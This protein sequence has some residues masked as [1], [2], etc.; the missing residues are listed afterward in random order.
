MR[1]RGRICAAWA[2]AA[3]TIVGCAYT[4]RSSLDPKYRT[5]AVPA[6]R[7]ESS[8]YDL[9][10]A[11]TNAVIRKFVAD[12]RLEV[13]PASQAAA[14]QADLV[15]EGVIRN[16][17]LEGMTYDRDD[18]VTQF[19]CKVTV[20]V[21]VMDQRAG[22]PL[23]E[24]PQLVNEMLFYTGATGPSS[25]RL[26]GNAETFLSS[27]RSFASVEEDRGASEALEQIASE[28]FIRTVEPW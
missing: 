14:G 8:E 2:F 13:V 24:E 20:G 11:L 5:I 6:F 15:V 28:I 25:D 12:G 10:A 1:A 26:R 7:N 27:V 3:L 22:K 4:T 23:W 18:E 19:M 21:R 16:Y 17:D 9:Q